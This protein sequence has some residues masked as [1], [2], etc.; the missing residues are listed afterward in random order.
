MSNSSNSVCWANCMHMYLQGLPVVG[1]RGTVGCYQAPAYLIN[2]DHHQS[3]AGMASVALCLSFVL[4]AWTEMV[5]DGQCMQSRCWYLSSHM[6][7][8]QLGMICQVSSRD[9]QSTFNQACRIFFAQH[10]WHTSTSELQ[11]AYHNASRLQAGAYRVHRLLH[12]IPATSHTLDASIVAVVSAADHVGFTVSRD[13]TV[14]FRFAHQPSRAPCHKYKLATGDRQVKQANT[15]ILVRMLESMRVFMDFPRIQVLIGTSQA[16]FVVLTTWQVCVLVI[17]LMH[18]MWR[19][20][21]GRP[22]RHDVCTAAIF[23]SVT[24]GHGDHT[25]HKYPVSYSDAVFWF[26]E[27]T[28]TF[29]PGSRFAYYFFKW[30]L[31]S[32]LFGSLTW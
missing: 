2:Q 24:R 19:R 27:S 28:R 14:H 15:H 25:I 10:K 23:C 4:T 9:R 5:V 13:W 20:R 17:I 30:H 21:S 22:R 29:F 3:A 8:H 6:R 16:L 18:H 32:A 11:W 1:L 7:Y 12:I 26:E 31:W